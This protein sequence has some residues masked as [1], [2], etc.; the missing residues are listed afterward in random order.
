MHTVWTG[1][2]GGWNGI[3]DINRKENLIE[4]NYTDILDKIME[5]PVYTYNFKQVDP[6]MKCFGPVAQ[7]FNRLFVSNVD[8]LCINSG[9]LAGI[10]LSGVKGVKLELDSLSTSVDSRF[11][12]NSETT[13]VLQSRITVLESSLTS[14]LAQIAALESRLAALETP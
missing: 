1:L 6:S 5:M 3:S 8:Q 9:N 10:T 2:I 12:S 4:Q 7:D 13:S 14:A 11:A